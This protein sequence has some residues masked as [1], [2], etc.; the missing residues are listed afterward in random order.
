MH[1]WGLGWAW[2]GLGMRGDVVGWRSIVARCCIVF[3]SCNNT[4][5]YS[6]YLG[7]EFISGYAWAPAINEHGLGLASIFPIEVS[8]PFIR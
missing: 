3:I 8:L 5:M 7:H 4:Y 6:A 1:I 2:F